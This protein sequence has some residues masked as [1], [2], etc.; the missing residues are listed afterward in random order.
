M[1]DVNTPPA[2]KGH[3]KECLCAETEDDHLDD[4]PNCGTS[5]SED[6]LSFVMFR[7]PACHRH[8]VAEQ[9]GISQR[10]LT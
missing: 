7:C 6:A 8:L 10:Y 4:C 5:I 9:N 3:D 2:H 1:N